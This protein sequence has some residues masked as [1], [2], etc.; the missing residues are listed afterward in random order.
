MELVATPRNPIPLGAAVG[1]LKAR[2]GVK[3]R[4]AH[5]RSALKQRYGTVCVFPGRSE[6]LE[7]YFE[8]FGELR[9]RGFAVA[10]LDW[11]GQGGSSRPG[12]ISLKGHVKDFAQYQ[13]DL[14]LFMNEVVLP[15]CPPPYY[16]LGHSMGGTVLLHAATQKGCW[17]SRMV[18]T[19]PMIKLV[20]LPVSQSHV[21]RILAAMAWCGFGRSSVPGGMKEYLAS[22][23]F[24]GNPL[25]SDRE[26]F[27]RNLSVLST[28]PELAGGPPT[29]GWVRGA[30]AAMAAIGSDT[31][32]PSVRVPT[33][34][35]AA[36]EDRIVS[37]KA[38]ED[39]SL[40][41]KVGTHILIRGARHE[42]LQERDAVRE[43][44]WAAFDAF[45][46]GAVPSRMPDRALA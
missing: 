3:L 30:L 1:F 27:L 34:L 18:L 24:E 31:F 45:I 19:A 13:E 38:V 42:I 44:F 2:R 4:Y 33:L 23:V 22:Q 7:K 5:W 37:S 14:T 8:V 26:R 25:T 28:A 35:L 15:D 32:P 9:R 39:L 11:R 29:V 6:F 43:Q 17:F 12:S 21:A 10:A 20:G 46:P 16:A 36:G 41:L 40:Y